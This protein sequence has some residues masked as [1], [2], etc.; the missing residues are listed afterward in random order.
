MDQKIERDFGTDYRKKEFQRKSDISK[1]MYKI[2]ISIVLMDVNKSLKF[3]GYKFEKAR[4][5][6]LA[7]TQYIGGNNEKYLNSIV[8]YQFTDLKPKGK[9]KNVTKAP[10]NTILNDFCECHDLKYKFLNI[11]LSRNARNLKRKMKQCKIYLTNILEDSN[12]S[13]L[14]SMFLY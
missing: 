14:F 1:M 11:E 6:L 5:D 2:P 13:F 12:V 9:N 8:H 3:Y 10:G 7:N 4:V